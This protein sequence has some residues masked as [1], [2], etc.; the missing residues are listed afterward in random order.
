M[1]DITNKR[2][3]VSNYLTNSSSPYFV[4]TRRAKETG[5]FANEHYLTDIFEML[6]KDRPELDIENDLWAP[7]TDIVIKS[8]RALRPSVHLHGEEW[9]KSPITESINS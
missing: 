5:K 2:K 8:I 6:K 4:S 1:D 9:M 7:I 3:H